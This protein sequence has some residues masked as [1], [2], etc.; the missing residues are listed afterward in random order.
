VGPEAGYSVSI[1]NSSGSVIELSHMPFL[2]IAS[3]LRHSAK[4]NRIVDN[5]LGFG[6]IGV[7]LS[8]CNTA[9][10]LIE[11][12]LVDNEGWKYFIGVIVQPSIW[13]ACGGAIPASSYNI[14]RGNEVRYGRFGVWIDDAFQRAPST[15]NLITGN[16]FA[17]QSD[18][19]LIFEGGAD[20]NDARGN[21]YVNVPVLAYDYGLGNL[22]P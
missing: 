4:G 19:G 20:Y 17:S 11:H 1:R 2:E 15:G 6:G 9:D 12:N 22:W 3:D 5:V 16:T 21:Q 14:V 8:G 10:N 18:A 13:A 7:A